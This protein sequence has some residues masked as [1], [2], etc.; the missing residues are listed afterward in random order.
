MKTTFKILFLFLL[1]FVG[2][3]KKNSNQNN[4]NTN[5]PP[6][7]TNLGVNKFAFTNCRANNLTIQRPS[8]YNFNTP[9]AIKVLLTN[10][11][12][13]IIQYTDT[14]PTTIS[15]LPRL[16]IITSLTN[17]G[18]DT[19]PFFQIMFYNNYVCPY[20]DSVSHPSVISYENLDRTL[21]AYAKVSITKYDAVGGLIEG[22][23][24]GKLLINVASLGQQYHSDSLII[25]GQ[26]STKR[27]QDG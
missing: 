20:L 18:T 9:Y 3:K 16:T 26:F 5:P 1:L 19:I 13:I 24:A 22:T 14:F 8:T 27:L 15:I 2:C 6:L 25:S 17:I 4:T 7:V 23:F 21:G 12:H 11:T 10:N